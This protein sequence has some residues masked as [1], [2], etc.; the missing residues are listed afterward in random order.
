[1]RVTLEL[2]PGDSFI[3]MKE[4]V[5]MEDAEIIDRFLKEVDRSTKGV[6]WSVFRG[7]RQ[8]CTEEGCRNPVTLVVDK[9]RRGL[10][11]KHAHDVLKLQ[12]VGISG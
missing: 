3:P 4:A 10:C 9:N 2:E 1:M 6:V 12:N 8:E 11:S 7:G 5:G